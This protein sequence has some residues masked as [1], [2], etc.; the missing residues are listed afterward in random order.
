[1]INN[2]FEK[3]IREKLNGAEST[4]SDGLLDTIFEKRAAKSRPATGFGKAGWMLA[5]AVLAVTA[6]VWFFNG[7]SGQQTNNEIA[8][9]LPDQSAQSSELNTTNSNSESDVINSEKQSGNTNAP[10]KKLRSQSVKPSVAA[11]GN[12]VHSNSNTNASQIARPA[13]HSNTQQANKTNKDFNGDFDLNSYFNVDAQ[14]RP[15]IDR[16]QHKGNSHVYVYHAVDPSA[17][18][19]ADIRNSSTSRIQKFTHNFESPDFGSAPQLALNNETPKKNKKPVFID[20]M[21]VPGMSTFKATQANAAQYNQVNSIGMTSQFGVRV[22]VPLNASLS[23][24]GGLYQN[25]QNTRYKGQLPYETS[26]QV[27]KTNVRYINDPIRGVIQVVTYDTQ[28][29]KNQMTQKVD[30]TNSYSLFRMPLGMSYNFGFGKFDFAVN[31]A[32]DI[33]YLRSANGFYINNETHQA[34]PF[35]LAKRSVNLGSSLSLMSA[36]KLSNKFRLILEPGVQYMN[37][38]A[39]HTGHVVNESILNFNFGLGLRYTVF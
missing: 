8:S 10:D 26:N 39:K 31:A 18:Q 6:G 20:L 34:N 37:L 5:A 30:H 32:M 2:S 4:P 28:N 11:S 16:E 3:Q 15:V 27:I 21:Y 33:N 12:Q 24:F 35:S 36:F 29:I 13:A 25:N 19:N 23:V 1:M 17:V 7:Q 14:N 22:S 9:V 38:K